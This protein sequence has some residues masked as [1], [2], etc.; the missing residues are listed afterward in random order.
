M[1]LFIIQVSAINT[2]IPS[3][4]GLGV[5]LLNTYFPE[6]LGFPLLYY[7]NNSDIPLNIILM[8]LQ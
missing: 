6:A 5:S 1:C 2:N 7:T 8:F 4:I 3:Y